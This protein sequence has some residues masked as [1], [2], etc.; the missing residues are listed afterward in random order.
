LLTAEQAA[1]LCKID[2][3]QFERL[4]I[5]APIDLAGER[6][7]DREMLEE[8]M[9]TGRPF[10]D[11]GGSYIY[12]VGFGPYVKIGFS[13]GPIES[14][15]AAL[16]TGCPEPLIVYGRSR[17]TM[18]H[19]EKMHIKF[20]AYRLRGEWFRNEGEVAAW[21]KAGCPLDRLP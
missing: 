2:A 19:E 10:S 14:R 8:W 21:I 15:L 4:C 3:D 20:A 6:R 18:W 17:G 16:Q 7:W 12:A 13:G 1:A 11:M 5:I 9:N